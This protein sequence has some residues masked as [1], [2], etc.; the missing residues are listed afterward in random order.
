MLWITYINSKTY[1]KPGS[2]P[3]IKYKGIV[4]Q[5]FGDLPETSI[6]GIKFMPKKTKSK[7]AAVEDIKGPF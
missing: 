7:K 1:K 2:E 3:I 6:G 4:N 5:I